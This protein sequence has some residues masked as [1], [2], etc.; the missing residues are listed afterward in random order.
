MFAVAEASC[1]SWRRMSGRCVKSS[2]GRPGVTRGIA[3][4]FSEPPS[5]RTLSGGRDTSTASALTFWSSV[6]RSGGTSAFWLASTLSCCATSRSV[7][8]PALRR[9]LMASRMR[10]ALAMLRCAVRSRS[11]EAST[12]K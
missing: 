4:L 1:A 11:C 6:W 12:W 2:D 9:S 7:P 8:V 3:I 5:T 10:C